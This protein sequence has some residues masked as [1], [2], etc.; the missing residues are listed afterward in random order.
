MRKVNFDEQ[1]YRNR[2]EDFGQSDRLYGIQNLGHI[3]WRKLH[4]AMRETIMV[5]RHIFK[6]GNLMVAKIND[7]TRGYDR[8]DAGSF[9]VLAEQGQLFRLNGHC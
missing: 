6:C 9:F 8:C 5:T 1:F 3:K 4:I 7:G 2:K